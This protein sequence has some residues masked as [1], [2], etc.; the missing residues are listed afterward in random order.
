LFLDQI[1]VQSDT[2][3]AAVNENKQ[4]I[5]TLT[6]KITEAVEEKIKKINLV[7]T[8]KEDLTQLKKQLEQR[9]DAESANIRKVL[10]SYGG[11]GSVATQYANGGTING[12][13]NIASGQILSGGINLYDIFSTTGASG[14][15]TLTFNDTTALLT[16]TPNGNT[17]SLSALSGG[18]TGPSGNT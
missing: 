6:T 10:A 15:Q 18:N 11:G 5:Q 9:I 12:T 17:I 3:N 1:K 7:A 14:Y 16:I 2:I 4:E 8:K 13:L